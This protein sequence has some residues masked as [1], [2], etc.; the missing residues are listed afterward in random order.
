MKF[1]RF[2]CLLAA[3][4]CM[5][6]AR[7][8]IGQ[9]F[10]AVMGDWKGDWSG[11]G[12]Q[13]WIGV[14][15]QSNG[16]LSGFVI[17]R[18]RGISDTCTGQLQANGTVTLVVGAGARRRDVSGSARLAA[19]AISGVAQYQESG[20]IISVK[21]S[22][23]RAIAGDFLM[24]S[25]FA[26]VWSGTWQTGITKGI[27]RV[28]VNAEGEV[29]GTLVNATYGNSAEWTGSVLNT[30]VFFGDGETTVNGSGEVISYEQVG[31]LKIAGSS[32]SGTVYIQQRQGPAA[33]AKIALKREVFQ[34]FEGYWFGTAKVNGTLLQFELEVAV[35]G[36][37][38]VTITD[39]SGSSVASV[40][41]LV[42]ANGSFA[43]TDENGAIHTGTLRKAGLR[44]TGS[45][46]E[47]AGVSRTKYTLQLVRGG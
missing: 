13:G 32:L 43:G 19:K 28:V 16:S 20:R 37:G 30:G 42:L 8:A 34:P 39:G 9:S 27:M 36:I 45:G 46:L 44:V 26:G 15:V 5:C 7:S 1:N 12:E 14:S 47:V 35:D 17:S 40:D 22:L 33:G 6:V 4:L 24:G 31:D 2:S 23:K 21:F 29:T 38:T 11:S 41:V 3:L 10:A 25:K 18:S